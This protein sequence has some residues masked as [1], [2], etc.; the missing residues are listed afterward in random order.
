MTDL[1]ELTTLRVGGPAAHFEEVTSEADFIDAIRTADA[2]GTPLLVIG[3][4]SNLLVA[5]AGFDGLVVRDARSAITVQDD[6]FCGGVSV[7]ATAG[8]VWDEVVE[9]AVADEWVGLEAL[10]GIP[11]SVG[12]APVQNIGA[13]GGELADTLASVRVWDRERGAVRT[14]VLVELG[15]GYRTSVLKRS[16]VAPYGPT[17]RYVVLDVTVHTRFGSR[18]AP[19]R[20][21]QLA[22]ALGVAVGETAPISEVR[23]AV[24]ALRSSKGMV[25]DAADYDTWSAGSFFTNP[26]V[27]ED[28]VPEGAPRYPASGGDVKTS[29]A[30]LIE[31]AGFTRGFALPGSRA[32]I[33][34]KHTLAL[35]NRGG[36]TSAELLALA[37]HIRAGVSDAFG[38]PL[39]P[40]PVVIDSQGALVQM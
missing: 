39:D 18:S 21:Q 19:I 28:Q 36:A 30:W 23:A 24:L 2:E 27:S 31:K 38:I 14:L 8:T 12:A 17:P 25:L 33:S 6:G 9:R 20:Y 10:S 3:G 34:S 15:F 5:D 16:L 29:A 4:G 7:T 11:G 40:E 35:T 26:V 32:A 13:Y 22:D 1:A 37:A